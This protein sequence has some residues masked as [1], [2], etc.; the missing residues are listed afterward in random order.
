MG[1]LPV[2]TRRHWALLGSQWA[3]TQGLCCPLQVGGFTMP[4][5]AQPSWELQTV[6]QAGCGGGDL[7]RGRAIRCQRCRCLWGP[8]APPAGI[9]AECLR[10][11]GRRCLPGAKM[12]E[13]PTV[14][15]RRTH[16]R[17][18]A[19]LTD[20]PGRGLDS[21]PRFR[22]VLG[23]RSPPHQLL[24]GPLLCPSVPYENICHWS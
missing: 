16:L 19:G 14:P 23:A 22:T 10:L 1:L 12:L 17:A 2:P 4:D 15:G 24:P 13:K 9:V 21:R 3:G 5:E 18:V 6:G 8:R 7:G 20:P 11:P